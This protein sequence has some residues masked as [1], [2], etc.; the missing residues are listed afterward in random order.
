MYAIGLDEFTQNHHIANDSVLLFNIIY[1][2]RILVGVRFC[3]IQ[4][5]GRATKPFIFS[6]L[7][8]LF[9]N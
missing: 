2:I 1:I 4:L 7:T 5:H 8:P 6:Q 3:S 9:F